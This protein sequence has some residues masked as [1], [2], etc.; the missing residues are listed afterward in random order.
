MGV[1]GVVTAG[2]GIADQRLG[3][4]AACVSWTRFCRAHTNPIAAITSCCVHL[5]TT[6]GWPRRAP[7]SRRRATRRTSSG[8]RRRS[9]SRKMSR[10][11]TTINVGFA[12]T[13]Y[14]AE[15][16]EIAEPKTSQAVN[17]IP[18]DCT[19]Q[20]RPQSGTGDAARVTTQSS[21]RSQNRKQVRPST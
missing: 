20:S 18:D 17:M 6:K 13:T 11:S 5:Q 2:D 8:I 12:G 1:D 19:T 14:N 16:A 7:P 15:H 10:M 4:S 3:R 21:Q 9:R